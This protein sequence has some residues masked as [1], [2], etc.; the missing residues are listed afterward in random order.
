MSARVAH[1]GVGDGYQS[2]QFYN[3]DPGVYEPECDFYDSGQPDYPDT[4]EFMAQYAGGMTEQGLDLPRE[5]QE[6]VAQEEEKPVTPAAEVPLAG[7][8]AG[9]GG[10]RTVPLY[11][12]YAFDQPTTAVQKTILDEIFMEPTE[13]SMAAYNRVIMKARV[14]QN[15]NRLKWSI[16]GHY[17]LV[18]AII[19]KLMPEILDKLDV[20]VLEVEELFVPKPLVWEWLWLLS[21]PVTFFGLSACNKSSFKN[22]KKFCLGTI[23][24]SVLP[25]VIGLGCHASDC[26]EFITE[27]MTDNIIIWQGFPYAVLWYVFFFV[28]VQIHLFELYF[29]NCLMQAWVPKKKTQ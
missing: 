22:I 3:N 4:D 24:C 2:Q 8:Y 11:T 26:Y 13:G 17:I 6:M 21:I 20:F 27:G 19:T 16:F 7:D 15:K 14:A 1:G 18:F 12:P 25:I 28:A 9:M 10:P 29:S 23:L 5:Q